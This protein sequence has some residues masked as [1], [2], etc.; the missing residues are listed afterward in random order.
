MERKLSHQRMY[1]IITIFLYCK[2]LKLFIFVISFKIGGMGIPMMGGPPPG[3]IKRKKEE[4]AQSEDS[5]PPDMNLGT[6]RNRARG[7]SKI[8]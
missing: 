5:S 7:P 4:A 3:L 1:I 8:F 2:K 6:I